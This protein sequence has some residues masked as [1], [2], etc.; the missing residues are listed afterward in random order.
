MSTQD[1][2]ADRRCVIFIFSDGIDRDFSDESHEA[3]I[4]DRAN[5]NDISSMRSR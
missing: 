2:L 5:K 1:K 3:L 4:V